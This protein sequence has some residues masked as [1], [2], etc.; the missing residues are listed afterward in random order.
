MIPIVNGDTASGEPHRDAALLFSPSP[1][2][3]HLGAADGRV[4][5]EAAAAL[6]DAQKKA[7]PS[8]KEG[9]V[10]PCVSQLGSQSLFQHG[11]DDDVHIGDVHHAV[12]VHVGIEDG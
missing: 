12:A 6:H 11:T 2:E 9:F 8:L 10:T 5:S 7:P 3:P 1:V 4:L